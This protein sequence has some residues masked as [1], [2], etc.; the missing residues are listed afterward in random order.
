MPVQSPT[1]LIRLLAAILAA[2]FA[3]AG[4]ADGQEPYDLVIR[5]GRIVDG[6]GNP[7]FRGD[8]AIR[9]DRIVA[10]GHIPQARAV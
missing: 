10:M 8:L 5:Q 4:S 2:T 7:W 6:T 3:Y 1:R 9:G